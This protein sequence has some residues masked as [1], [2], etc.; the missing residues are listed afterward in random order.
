MIF[1]KVWA[2]AYQ[3]NQKIRFFFTITGSY[4]ENSLIIPNLIYAGEFYSVL[5]GYWK[6]IKYIKYGGKIEGYFDE[7]TIYKNADYKLGNISPDK[8]ESFPGF[9]IN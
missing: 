6:T 1:G 5:N 2:I 7:I 4:Y 9:G 3:K 8:I